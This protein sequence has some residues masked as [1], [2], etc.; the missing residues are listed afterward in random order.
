[1]VDVSITLTSLVN[2]TRS[3]DLVGGGSSVTAG[4]TFEIVANN[5]TMDLVVVLE[6]QNGGAAVI[7]FDAGDYPPSLRRSLGELEITLAQADLRVVPLEGGRFIQSDGKITGSV[8]TNTVKITAL[9]L[10]VS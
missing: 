8:A 7:T 4:Q 6:E 2:N 1:M 3:N 10:P 5:E 9:K